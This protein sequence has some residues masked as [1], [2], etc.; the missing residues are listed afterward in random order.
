MKIRSERIQSEQNEMAKEKQHE[1]DQDTVESCSKDQVDEA[2]REENSLNSEISEHL[3]H[4]SKSIKRMFPDNI[5]DIHSSFSKLNMK[6]DN[7]DKKKSHHKL[8]RSRIKQG[9]N[10]SSDEQYNDYSPDTET[11]TQTEENK[12]FHHHRA[13][14]S[15]KNGLS[16]PP[17]VESNRSTFKQRCSIGGETNGYSNDVFNE[18]VKND[19]TLDTAHFDLSQLAEMSN[20][21]FKINMMDVKSRYRKSRR[22]KLLEL[23]SSAS[24]NKLL[25]HKIEDLEDRRSQNIDKEEMNTAPR[26]ILIHSHKKITDF[27]P[28]NK[29]N[30][31]IRDDYLYDQQEQSSVSDLSG[32]AISDQIKSFENKGPGKRTTEPISQGVGFQSS[33]D[34]EQESV[35]RSYKHS[36][37]ES[38]KRSSVQSNL[39]AP[40][41]LKQRPQNKST[42][43]DDDP[44]LC[45]RTKTSNCPADLEGISVD[46]SSQCLQDYSGGL[47]PTHQRLLGRGRGRGRSRNRKLKMGSTLGQTPE[48]ESLNKPKCDSYVTSE[49]TNHNSYSSQHQTQDDTNEPI[50]IASNE[51]EYGSN[52]EP[53]PDKR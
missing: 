53:V 42:D 41:G 21:D 36:D 16:L 13:S 49:T 22:R 12:I 27:F 14:E 40:N 33:V 6:G 20:N 50:A 17:V 15:S 19:A 29:T 38:T 52:L 26:E 39:G 24:S 48:S 3:M 9:I 23:R 7:Q 31:Q 25:Q 34:D 4:D 5:E 8:R 51:V 45:I 47:H 18:E 32:M 10:L 30:E 1:E 28:Q 44:S 2:S 11:L 43:I 35:K 46:A 37:I